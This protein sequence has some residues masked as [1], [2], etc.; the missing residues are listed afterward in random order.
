MLKTFKAWL[1]GSQLEWIGDVPELGEQML[2]VHVTFLDD[3]S[4]LES[5]TRGQRMAE[6]LT[7]LAATQELDRVD[8]AAW[9]Q[10]I[11]QDR[12]LPGR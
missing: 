11:R 7:N 1:K 12:S 10:E 4:V 6:I 9:Q 8:P 5:K 2:Q 3:K